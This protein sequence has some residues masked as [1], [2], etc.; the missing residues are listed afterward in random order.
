MYLIEFV[1]FTH[2]DVLPKLEPLRQA[3]YTRMFTVV[4]EMLDEI[5][6]TPNTSGSC[7]WCCAAFFLP[8]GQ[9]T[10]SRSPELAMV[11]S[12]ER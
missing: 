9:S 6:G 11:S 1:R 2:V 3:T 4:G 7:A 10:P 5:A 12:G 8:P